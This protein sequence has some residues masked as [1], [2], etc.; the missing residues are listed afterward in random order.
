MPGETEATNDDART[1]WTEDDTRWVYL[2]DAN[3]R[4]RDNPRPNLVF[5]QADK[6]ACRLLRRPHQRAP[7]TTRR[8][9]L[10]S[11]TRAPCRRVMGVPGQRSQAAAVS[12]PARSIS[13]SCWKC[14]AW[15]AH[16]GSRGFHVL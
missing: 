4:E 3:G 2:Y 9:R 12:A 5:D 14:A 6:R 8:R 16:R 13:G 15:L 1:A 11:I 10:S 7:Y